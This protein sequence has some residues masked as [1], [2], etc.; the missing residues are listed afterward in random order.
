[1]AN[2]SYDTYSE[3]SGSGT[4][5]SGNF[6]VTRNGS[7]QAGLNV[8][9]H[10]NANPGSVTAPT[11]GTKAMTYRAGGNS[12]L[13]YCYIYSLDNSPVGLNTLSVSWTN[14][15]NY[16]ISIVSLG[17]TDGY[18]N[19]NQLGFSDGGANNWKAVAVTSQTG[20]LVV[21]GITGKDAWID[22]DTGTRLKLDSTRSVQY[23]AG[24]ASVSVSWHITYNGNTQLGELVGVSWKPATLTVA[25]GIPVAMT[26]FMMI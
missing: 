24:A 21:G 12:G 26:P 4:S 17:A 13:A 16:W 1:M 8:I 15:V 2:A 7:Y 5:Y 18:D 25:T 14:S 11:Y 23:Y 3:V 20:G 22:N 9:L 19:A 6:T 10:F